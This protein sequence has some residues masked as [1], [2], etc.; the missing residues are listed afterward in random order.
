MSF[1]SFLEL[2]KERFGEKVGKKIRSEN[3]FETF[4]AII[5]I[6][7]LNGAFLCLSF[8]YAFMWFGQLND[9]KGRISLVFLS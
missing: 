6:F 8:F 5:E 9:S 1:F 2:F 3:A 7:W 4:A